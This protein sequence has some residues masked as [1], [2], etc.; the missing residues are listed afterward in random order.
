MTIWIALTA[1][2]FFAAYYAGNWD[3]AFERSF[4]QFIAV[5]CVWLF[6]RPKEDAP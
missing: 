3:S 1:G 2:N 6:V 4:F 5:F